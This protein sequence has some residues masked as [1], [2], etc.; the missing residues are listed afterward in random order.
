[1]NA[2]IID[3]ESLPYQRSGIVTTNDLQKTRYSLYP[4]HTD[5]L[6]ITEKKSHFQ[7]AT[8][9][10]HKTLLNSMQNQF[11]LTYIHFFLFYIVYHSCTCFTSTYEYIVYYSQGHLGVVVGMSGAQTGCCEVP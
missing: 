3:F 2:H 6:L 7:K 8:E 5:I 10:S 1:M 9:K 11:S 4:G